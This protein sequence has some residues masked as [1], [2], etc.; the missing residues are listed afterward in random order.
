M[1]TVYQARDPN[2]EFRAVQ[3]A[4]VS[5]GGRVIEPAAIAREMQNHE[6]ATPLEA[7]TDAA[8]ALVVRELLTQEAGRLEMKPVPRQDENGRQETDD[9]ALIR[10]VVDTQISSPT[11]NDADCRRYY[12]KNMQ[13]FRSADLFHVSH[14]LLAAPRDDATSRTHARQKADDLL[15]TLTEYPEQFEV[16]AGQHSDCPSGA[17]GGNL[18]Q[19]KNGDTVP[20]FVAALTALSSGTISSRPIETRYGFHIVRLDTRIEGRQMPFDFVR[21]RIAAYLNERATR[22]ATAQY[23][24]LLASQTSIEGI[25]LPTPFDVGALPQ[26]SR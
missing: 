3:H 17:T 20:E 13:R 6:A 24:A 19:I 25:D 23:L 8:R 9:E 4:R 15:A 14:I 21:E 26:G 5:V 1:T 22:L 11:P 18:G 10:G 16:L 7:W 12:E 2:T